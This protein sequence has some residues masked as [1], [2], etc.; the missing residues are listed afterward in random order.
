VAAV[1]NTPL[2]MLV[3]RD[4]KTLAQSLTRLDHAIAKAIEDDIFT[5]EINSPR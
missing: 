2:A 3:R 5:D 1:E 4:G